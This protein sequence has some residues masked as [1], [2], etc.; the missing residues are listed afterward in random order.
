MQT[1]LASAYKNRRMDAARPLALSLGVSEI[2]LV[3]ERLSKFLLTLSRE[4]FQQLFAQL[5][6]MTKTADIDA[7]IA[8]PIAAGDYVVSLCSSQLCDFGTS[9]F[10]SLLKQFRCLSNAYAEVSRTV[11]HSFSSLFRVLIAS[12]WTLLTNVIRGAP[13]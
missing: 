4:K 5:P 2:V 7:I 13:V 11:T 6:Q 3:R 10:V 8:N 1:V 9:T 12:V